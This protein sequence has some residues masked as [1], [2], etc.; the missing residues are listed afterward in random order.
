MPKGVYKRTK[1]AWNKGLTKE[2][3][4]RVRINSQK[5]DETKLKRYGSAN[6]NNVDKIKKTNIAKYGCE[7]AFHIDKEANTKKRKETCLEKYGVDV[8]SKNASIKEK[9]E[10][11]FMKNHNGYKN[12][13]SLDEVREKINKKIA[14]PE[15]QVKKEKTCLYR[16]GV[17]SALQSPEIMKKKLNTTL[18]RYGVPF[19]S[20]KEKEFATKKR[21]NSYLKHKSKYEQVIEK[22]LLEKYSPE[23]II[24][25]Y[26]DN[27]YPF[28]AD[29]YI[30]SIDTYIEVNGNW[31]HGPHPFNANSKN[32]V[33]LLDKW[34]EK[35]KTSKYY[36]NAIYTWTELDVRKLQH[37]INNNINLI[38]I[39]HEKDND[40]VYTH[41]K[42][43]EESSPITK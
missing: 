10:N 22:S 18:Q 28:V 43:C 26:R 20:N 12:N 8:V 32:D 35:A 38:L 6:Y 21:N 17:K 2:T 14:S 5:R 19:Y 9:A 34:K 23:D 30:K 15:I 11:T 31:T 13:F 33:E 16:Y 39:Y 41:K 4:D 37:A 40:I 3:D 25:Q 36:Q 1:P 29:F 7:F 27:N 24:Y 42:L